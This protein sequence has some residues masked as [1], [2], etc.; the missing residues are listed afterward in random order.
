[1]KSTNRIAYLMVAIAGGAMAL[2]ALAQPVVDEDLGSITQF[3]PA[4]ISRTVVFDAATNPVQ[5]Y[6]IVLPT[7][8]SSNAFLD[9]F[10]HA[11][12]GT[13]TEIG[14]YR[15]DGTLVDSDDDDGAATFSALSYGSTTVAFA[16]RV[17]PIV[18]GTQS[19]G[20]NSNGR[21]G[22][23]D[24]VAGTY[25]IAVSKFNATFG[26]TGFA[27]TTTGTGTNTFSFTLNYDGI[28]PTNPVIN[29][30]VST[31]NSGAIGQTFLVVANV[32]RAPDNVPITTVS[33]DASQVDGGT[34]ALNDSGIAPDVT[35]GDNNWSGNVTIGAGATVGAKT[36]TANLTDG[37]ARTAIG[38][39][40]FSVTPA[41]D[42]CVNATTISNAGPYPFNFGFAN[43]GATVDG[44]WTGCFTATPTGP[45][46]WFRWTAPGNGTLLLSSCN[47]DTGFSGTQPDTLLGV[48]T[49]CSSTFSV[50]EDDQGGTCG[51]GTSIDVPVFA[52]VEYWIGVRSWSTSATSLSGL[53]NLNFVIGQLPAGTAVT[54][55]TAF[56]NNPLPGGATSVTLSVT[57]TSGDLPVSVSVDGSSAGFGTVTLTD[58]DNDNT[59]TAVVP[60]ASFTGE[61][62]YTLPFTITDGTGD[63]FTGNIVAN[64]LPGVVDLGTIDVNSPAI[65]VDD[66]SVAAAQVRWFSFNLACGVDAGN[67][68]YLDLHTNNS[69]LGDSEIG[70]YTSDGNLV[71]SDDDDALGLKSLLTFG[72]GSSE[73]VDGTDTTAVADGR[74][75]ATLAAGTY[76]LAAGP[77]NVNFGTTAFN[78]SST[79]T[80][81]GT[82]DINLLTNLTCGPTCNDID[83]NNDGSLFDPT[84]IDAFLS[85]F[86][87]GPCVPAEA[88]CDGI[89][90]NNDTS[91]FDPC[92]IDAFLLVFSEGPCTLCGV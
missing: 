76:Y 7:V 48:T 31:P 83:I 90:F 2:P 84:D 34:V 92:D 5:W 9:M 37:S 75:G 55:V 1:M 72:T 12:T 44:T 3:T 56:A 6:Q 66:A 46:T 59:F 39:G 8:N 86:S 67:S 19:A 71:A 58:P 50:C 43:T 21:D 32:S 74:D 80:G 10:T 13:D 15:A 26:T 41:N 88:T 62:S 27:V 73:D 16:G 36:L 35:P 42:N 28:A 89:D 54:P 47:A 85:V 30:V 61:G 24:I 23:S 63:N 17:N 20:V 65:L 22:A 49:A 53:V 18:N 57:V 77:F 64:I 70:L 45:D 11:T 33:L 91:L 40:S 87:E 38:T 60:A 81:S 68:T 29:S 51:L 69:G 14:L 25:Y 78:V 4:T 52:G 79:G 82:L